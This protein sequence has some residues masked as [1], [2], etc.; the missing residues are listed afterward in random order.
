[1]ASN[2]Q[3]LWSTE[4]TEILRELW[5]E[6]KLSA[7][8]I[9]SALNETPG[10]KLSRNAIHGKV[11]RLHLGKRR[12][13]ARPV[14]RPARRPALPPVKVRAHRPDGGTPLRDVDIPPWQLV[15]IYAA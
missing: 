11:W 4:R 14:N 1:M 9:A 8:E 7:A 15:T 5:K 6:A 10:A 3:N 12:I 2:L 13:G